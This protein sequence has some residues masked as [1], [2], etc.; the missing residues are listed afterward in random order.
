MYPYLVITPT[1]PREDLPPS[2][3][4]Q[5]RKKL[6]LN[7]TTNENER[8]EDW[9]LGHEKF[10]EISPDDPDLNLD[11]KK[12]IGF[13]V[14]KD[15]MREVMLMDTAQRLP[16]VI[17]SLRHDLAKCEKEMGDLEEK[18]RLMDPREIKLMVGDLLEEVGKRIYAYLDGDLETAYKFPTALQDLDD[19]L[20]EEEESEWSSRQLG[21]NATVD[22][23]K[24]WR[25]HLDELIQKEVI[26]NFVYPEKKFLGGKQFQRA[27]EVMKVAMAGNKLCI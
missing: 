7:A 1:L 15:K 19:E 24:S 23:E 2:E 17:F 14:A 3:L 10:R 5:E 20:E 6:L 25:E 12:R 13:S 9:Q 21:N 8:F 26:P 22:E 27:K 18:K 16:E 11:I 4:L